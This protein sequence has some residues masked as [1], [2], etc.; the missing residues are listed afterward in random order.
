MAPLSANC[1][2]QRSLGSSTAWCDVPTHCGCAAACTTY[3]HRWHSAT[4]HRQKCASSTNP[5]LTSAACMHDIWR[6]PHCPCLHHTQHAV[7]L[8]A[9]GW[10][11]CHYL[12]LPGLPQIVP[13]SK[14]H[15]C[16]LAAA[17]LRLPPPP[18]ASSTCFQKQPALNN[19]TFVHKQ[20]AA[21]DPGSGRSRA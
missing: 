8:L 5:F 19:T 7:Q 16:H 17:S 2:R 18:A 14:L 3:Q 9:S 12:C 15:A 6:V 1:P 4:P 13:H 10:H 11:H 20:V 21:S